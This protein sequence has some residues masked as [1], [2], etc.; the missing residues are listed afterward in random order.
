MRLITGGHIHT[1]NKPFYEDLKLIINIFTNLS[2]ISREYFSSV[3]HFNPIKMCSE[4]ILPCQQ[5][6]LNTLSCVEFRCHVGLL[7]F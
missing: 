4:R 7:Q 6:H 1:R 5:F 2:D 3:L